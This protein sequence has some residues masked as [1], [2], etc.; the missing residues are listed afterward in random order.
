MM[1]KMMVKSMFF[2]SKTTCLVLIPWWPA[3]LADLCG[4]P[5]GG[6]GGLWGPAW[7]NKHGFFRFPP[8]FHH[9][10]WNNL[11]NFYFLTQGSRFRVFLFVGFLDVDLIIGYIILFARSGR[12]LSSCWFSRVSVTTNSNCTRSFFSADVHGEKT[13]MSQW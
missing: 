5:G 1:A 6:K 3:G 10:R 9:G 13:T 2:F 12:R 8:C 7:W 4:C 11:P